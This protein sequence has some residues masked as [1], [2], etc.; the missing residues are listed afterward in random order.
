MLSQKKL[1]ANK[2]NAKKSTGA[3]TAA[4]KRRASQNARRHG[5][6][7]SACAD[8]ALSANVEGLA[9]DLCGVHACP[10]LRFLAR[11]VAEAHVDIQRVRSARILLLKE[12]LAV[13]D[14]CSPK[15][16]Q[17]KARALLEIFC[18]QLKG[19]KTVPLRLLWAIEP[20]QGAATFATILADYAREFWRYDQYERRALSRRDRAIREFDLYVLDARAQ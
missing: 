15:N 17:K 9:E 6:S 4:G 18:R 16:I 5:L 3:R 1:A 13:Q 8:P 20:L 2:A 11:R 7:L 10:E 12:E 19:D 14:Y